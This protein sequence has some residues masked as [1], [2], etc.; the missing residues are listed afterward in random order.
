MEGVDIHI[1]LCPVYLSTGQTLGIISNRNVIVELFGTTMD[2]V[3]QQSFFIDSLYHNAKLG[4]H[5]S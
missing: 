1:F 4:I 5:G 3:I 2:H